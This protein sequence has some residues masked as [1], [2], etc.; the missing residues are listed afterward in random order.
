MSVSSM[1]SLVLPFLQKSS[2]SSVIFS[3]PALLSKEKTKVVPEGS[4]KR[5]RAHRTARLRCHLLPEEYED[6][7][8]VRNSIQELVVVQEW[9]DGV[10]ESCVHFIHFI[11]YEDWSGTDAHVSPNPWLQLVLSGTKTEAAER[12]CIEKTKNRTGAYWVLY[13]FQLWHFNSF[14]FLAKTWLKAVNKT[15]KTRCHASTEKFWRHQETRLNKQ[16]SSSTDVP[17]NV[18]KMKACHQDRG[19]VPP[20]NSNTKQSPA[21]WAHYFWQH[22]G[23]NY[24]QCYIYYVNST[25]KKCHP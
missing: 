19:Q 15:Y 5:H 6:G 25:T 22:F 7:F 2:A 16:E 8:P 3:A 21:K 18:S 4:F 13:S 23:Q 20:R 14:S 10:D 24:K 11:K 17:E 1:S 12:I 9:L